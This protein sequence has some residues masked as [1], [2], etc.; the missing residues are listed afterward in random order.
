V[1]LNPGALLCNAKP[2]E[3]LCKDLL[4]KYLQKLAKP[5]LAR[6]EQMQCVPMAGKECSG[7]GL[8]LE[9][10]PGVALG[11]I[12]K[13]LSVKSK[14][15]LLR[16]GPVCRD[17]LLAESRS[18]A[19]S[20]DGDESATVHQGLLERACSTPGL[21][22]LTLNAD[23][24]RWNSQL[25]QRNLLHEL[26]EPFT[27]GTSSLVNVSSLQLQVSGASHSVEACSLPA[28]SWSA[29]HAFQIQ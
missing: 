5:M 6:A 26:L 11:L 7:Q 13:Q 21:S 2:A 12:I 15:K 14:G 9:S 24:C 29:G 10:L 8:D 22:Q 18:A 17:A 25:S 3:Q 23:G 4:P 19:L 27:R 28:G 16:V 20:I 1:W